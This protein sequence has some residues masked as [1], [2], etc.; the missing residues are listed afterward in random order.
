MFGN[1]GTTLAAFVDDDGQLVAA[2]AYDPLTHVISTPTGTSLAAAVATSGVIGSRQH[3]AALVS[4]VVRLD[5]AYY[6]WGGAHIVPTAGDSAGRP[7]GRLYVLRPL[8]PSFER[9]L[10][11][12]VDGRV[13]LHPVADAGAAADATYGLTFADAEVA[14]DARD[15]DLLAIR[16]PAAG[17]GDHERLDIE[18]DSSRPVHAR[19]IRAT[20]TLLW[21]TLGAGLVI[22]L[23]ALVFFDRFLLRPLQAIARGL[24]EI[25]RG[26]DPGARLPPPRR[27][28]EIGVVTDA[29]NQMLGELEETKRAAD[30]ARDAALTASRIKSE[31][32]ARMS[33][34]IRTPMNGVLGMTELLTRTDL[35]T[36]QRKFSDTIHR[37]ALSLL[38]IINDILDFSKIE[39]KRLELTPVRTEIG[40][41]VEEALE[42]LGPRAHARGLELVL[43]LADSVPAIAEVDPVRLGQV[44][45]NLIGNAIKFTEQGEVVVRVESTPLGPGRAELSFAVT[46]TGIGIEAAALERI[47]EPFSQADAGTSQRFGGTGLGLPIARQLVELMG[48]QL[49]VTSTPNCGST[50]RFVIAVATHAEPR[51]VAAPSLHGLNVL[52]A[53]LNA[54]SRAVLSRQLL[55][56]GARVLG[57]AGPDVAAAATAL[58]GSLLDFAVVSQGQSARERALAEAVMAEPAFASAVIVSLVSNADA[59]SELEAEGQARVGAYLAKPVRRSLLYATLARL[60][61]RDREPV[62]A[63][64]A[65]GATA[66]GPAG[67]LGLTVLVVEDNP[68]NQQVAVGMLQ[69]L[70]CRSRVAGNGAEALARIA[71]GGID[72]VLMDCHMPVM[73]GIE[74]TK[75]LRVL[76]ASERRRRLPVIGVSAHALQTAQEECRRAG[77]NDFIAKPFTVA[78]LVRTL[79]RHARAQPVSIAGASAG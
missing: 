79:A 73:D 31:F 64:G 71:E 48:G 38:A 27:R 24:E 57:V 10:A 15:T 51:A 21:S 78:E 58:G 12:S 19:A 59:V 23:L 9:S 6:V 72:A 37:S 61:G 30:T 4:G 13:V 65:A 66:I 36:R 8:S 40:T 75:R 53:D 5:G 50:F 70:G 2:R 1:Q 11:D 41:L 32:L 3:G 45:N 44:L 56:Q 68:V 77:M 20:R 35:S 69:I 74:A 7:V 25:G 63:T 26:G 76:E 60:S 16:F 28:D 29:A 39:A 14:F 46:D 34:E 22:G 17:L 67:A 42:L 49:A 55:A 52:V 18:I 62:P 43:D 33:H 47:F 54:S